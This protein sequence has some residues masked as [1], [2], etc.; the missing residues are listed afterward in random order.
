MTDSKLSR[1]PFVQD[2]ET[3]NTVRYK[4]ANEEAAEVMDYAY[5]Q[6]RALPSDRFP[7]VV[8]L[9]LELE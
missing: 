6:K 3:K 4:A 9:T 1:V 8:Y 7:S 5:V 2:Q